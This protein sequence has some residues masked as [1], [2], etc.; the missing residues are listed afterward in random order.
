MLLVIKLQHFSMSS[1]TQLYRQ[2]FSLLSQYSQYR[3]LRHLKTLA[4]MVCALVGSQKLSLP[5]WESYVQ[6]KA[7]K[8]QSYERRW[9]R[10]MSNTRIKVAAL[11]LPLVL[12]AMS[13]WAKGRVYLGLDTTMLWNRYCMIHITVICGGRAVP[14]L[15]K[16]LEHKSASV[17]FCEYYPLLRKAHWLLRAYPDVM[18]LGDRGFSNQ[19]MVQWLQKSRW[20]WAV[21][22][23]C[24][25]LV[26]GPLRYPVEVRRLWPPIN[27][28]KLYHNVRLWSEAQLQVNLVL[29]YPK[30]VDEPWAVITDER[31]TLETLWQYALRFRL[32]ELF[33]DSKSGAFELED[34]RVRNALCLERLYLVAALAILYAT[35]HGMALQVAGLRQKV[36]PHWR[37][38]LSY[39]KIGLR[40]LSGVLHKGRNILGLE[41]FLQHDPQP[42]FASKKA[43][44]RFYN[45]IWFSRLKTIRCTA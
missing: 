18:L 8:A 29:A 4:W 19:S 1:S 40:W 15:W 36:D 3:D 13:G 14:L 28:A 45:Q 5:E 32:E 35:A 43:R 23:P 42:C 44:Q 38:G 30:G 25:V 24:D 37:R 16:V 21:R 34:S 22:L 31:P 33:L 26:S 10:F 41:P 20:H 6:S 12:A 9:K 17:E 2:I 39:L 7:Q 27:E 11:Y